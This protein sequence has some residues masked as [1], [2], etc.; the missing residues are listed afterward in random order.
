MKSLDLLERL[1]QTSDVLTR[2][3]PTSLIVLGGDFNQSGESD[4]IERTGIILLNQPTGDCD[5][6]VKCLFVSYL[7]S[8]G[9]KILPSSIRTNHK[10]H[11]QYF[12]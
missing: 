10:S 5:K 1:E 7:C 2:I 3:D 12:L 11:H 4:V 6:I 9:V 8:G